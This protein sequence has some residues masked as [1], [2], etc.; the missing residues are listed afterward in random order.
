M[1]ERVDISLG[2][3]S[4]P[5]LIGPDLL[6]DAATLNEHV[7]AG[8]LLAV[9][10]AV[11]APLYLERLKRV[12]A[13]RRIESVILPDGEQYKTL[14]SVSRI[15]DALVEHRMNRDAAVLA[16]GG[17]VV[18][19]MAGFAAACYQR[20]IDYIQ[21]PTTL[22]AQVDSSV[23]GKT[24]VNHPKAKNMIGAF[25]QPRCVIADTRTLR[26]LPEREYR[27]GLAETIKYGFIWDASFLNWLEANAT[28]LL[29]RDDEAIMHAVRRSCEIKAQVVG[30]DEREQGLRAILNFG[31]T[32]GHAIETAAGYGAWLHGEA[33]G[34]GMVVATDMSHRLGWL[35]S[36]QRDRAIELVKRFELPTAAP[37]ISARR[38]Q[39]LMGLDK[40]VLGGRIRLVLLRTLG[41]AL[42]TSDY[43][44]EALNDALHA[45]FD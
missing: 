17:G 9:T 13:G 27:A 34:A 41:E 44:D 3:R 12:L 21:V 33:V 6:S 10:N 26:T 35:T 16:L 18:G 42:I 39:E 32:F 11:V 4:Y 31:H 40:K 19:D 37:K 5:I 14:D 25:H 24:A 23:G 28:A 20:G 38:A 2:E 45:H 22:L 29:E 8:A 7:K 15:I 43:P 36:E 30:L 1:R